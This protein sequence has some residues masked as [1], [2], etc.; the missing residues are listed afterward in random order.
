M[1]KKNSITQANDSI[2]RLTIEDL[3][4]EMNELLEVDLQQIVGGIIW[5]PR[6]PLPP[7]PFSHEKLSP[8]LPRPPR[9]F[10]HEKISQ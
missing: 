7:R 1:S 3:P 4:S 2:N 8:R 6:P 10:S 9:P 5:P